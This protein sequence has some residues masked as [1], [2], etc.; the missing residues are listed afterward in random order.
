MSIARAMRCG[1]VAGPN[2]RS[3]FRIRMPV[4]CAEHEARL[5]HALVTP[6]LKQMREVLRRHRLAA[7]VE[8]HVA[9]RRK[10]LGDLARAGIGP[11]GEFD[12]PGQAL[13]IAIDQLALRRAADFPARDDV[14]ENG[15]PRSDK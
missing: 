6:S 11:L 4:R 9:E 14:K 10:R 3:R 15:A 13:G 7:L 2:A 1:H 12:R 5:A 8:Q